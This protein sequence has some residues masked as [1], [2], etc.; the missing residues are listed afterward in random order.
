MV[1]FACP[2]LIVVDTVV[3]VCYSII[4]YCWLVICCVV[5]IVSI[6]TLTII[7]LCYC[8]APVHCSLGIVPIGGCY[9]CL[10]WVLLCISD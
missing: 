4:V 3:D 1:L 7:T 2:D 6:V 5:S 10:L 9:C 8:V